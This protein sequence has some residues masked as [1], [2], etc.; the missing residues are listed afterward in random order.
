MNILE[1]KES[2]KSLLL[3]KPNV[4]GVGVGY[5]VTEGVQ[6]DQVALVAMVEKK[7][8]L[9]ALS[10]GE[11]LPV[12]VMDAPVDVI[13]VGKLEALSYTYRERP[14]HPGISIGHYQITAGTFGAV[15]Y[16]KMTGEPLLLSN[17]HVFA[18]SNE[19][20]IGDPILQP[21]PYDGGKVEN[22]TIAKLL[23]YVPLDFGEDDPE[24]S[25]ADTFARASN[26][27]S[28][29][30]GSQHKVKIVKQNALATNY[31]DCAVARPVSDDLINAE[32]TDIGMVTET[33][34]HA[35]GMAVHKTGRTTEHTEGTI[36]LVNA[37]VNVGY[38]GSKVATFEDQIVT[39]YMSQGGDS[40]SLLVSKENN[41]AVGLL[42]AGSDRSTIFNPIS[43]VI[44]ML[45]IHF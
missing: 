44:E 25:I 32:I 37:T 2:A 42:F 39:G 30:L 6:T 1:L 28:G 16:D 43:R 4:V 33:E 3:E 41:K 29:V 7:K 26:F 20:E 11:Q 24:C 21:G 15:V 14:A 27:L 10:A 17:N 34:Q 40:G 8:P 36:T 22:D 45:R 18:N 23:R 12:S 38:G 31:V 5:K 19:A 9:S 13:E 35:L